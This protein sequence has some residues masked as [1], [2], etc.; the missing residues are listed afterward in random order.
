MGGSET[1][2]VF[3]IMVNPTQL[4]YIRWFREGEEKEC[5]R[6][7]LTPAG[8]RTVQSVILYVKVD[9][10]KVEISTMDK[11]EIKRSMKPV[12][13]GGRSWG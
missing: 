1:L 13:R 11:D 10:G 12:G 9:G 4:S 2:T 6:Y 5:W 8:R 3:Y 7:S